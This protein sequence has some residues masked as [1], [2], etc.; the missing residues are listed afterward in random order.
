[1]ADAGVSA[2]EEAADALTRGATFALAAA[3]EIAVAI[4]ATKEDFLR[5]AIGNWDQIAGAVARESAPQGVRLQ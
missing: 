4:G 3:I 2:G 1:M 5:A